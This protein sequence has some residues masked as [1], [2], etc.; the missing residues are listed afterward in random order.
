MRKELQ[1]QERHKNLWGKVFKIFVSGFAC[2]RSEGNGRRK[3]VGIGKG[4]ARLERGKGF[5]EETCV[6]GL[7]R[8]VLHLIHFR[9]QLCFSPSAIP[10]LWALT[11]PQI[12]RPLRISVPGSLLDFRR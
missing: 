12:Q 9:A 1:D 3:Q 2:T 5:E 7:L 8:V 11:F 10:V 4:T 6:T